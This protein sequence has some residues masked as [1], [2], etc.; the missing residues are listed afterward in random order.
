M[1]NLWVGPSPPAML[2]LLGLKNCTVVAI[3]KDGA[4]VVDQLVGLILFTISQWD[5][6]MPHTPDGWRYTECMQIHW[7]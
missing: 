5:I 3:G 6:V 1:P 4:N 2:K 7:I